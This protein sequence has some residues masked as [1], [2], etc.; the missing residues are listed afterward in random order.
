MLSQEEAAQ[1]HEIHFPICGPL[2]IFYNANSSK[3]PHPLGKGRKAFALWYSLRQVTF[4]TFLH[5]QM[6]GNV[7]YPMSVCSKLFLVNT[8]SLFASKE[9]AKTWVFLSLD[10]RKANCENLLL[11]FC[12]VFSCKYEWACCQHWKVNPVVFT[13]WSGN[14]GCHC[15]MSWFVR[16]KVNWCQS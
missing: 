10:E 16:H 11:F 15:T 5:S 14:S 2:D 4:F 12:F 13:G 8:N 6:Q 9:D 7:P 1:S 3:D